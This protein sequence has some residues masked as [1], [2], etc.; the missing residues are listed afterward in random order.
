[1]EFG[2]ET[3]LFE[4]LGK[5]RRS[6]LVFVEEMEAEWLFQALGVLEG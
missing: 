3:H 5:A 4:A 6:E 1:V 2:E